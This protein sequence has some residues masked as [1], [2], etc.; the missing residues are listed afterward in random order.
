MT[1]RPV[2]IVTVTFEGLFFVRL[3]V[4]KIR[5]FTGDRPYE[6]IAVDRGSR[7][8]TRAWLKAQPDVR[9]LTAWQWRRNRHD[10]GRAAERG[11]RAAVHDVIVLVDSDAHPVA[12]D[13]LALTADRLS[14]STRLAG[15]RTDVRHAGNAHGWYV[16]PHF[17]VF[18][19]SDLDGLVVLRKVRGHDT[20]T[21]EEATIRML[22]AGYGVLG[23]PMAPWARFSRPC[24][25]ETRVP[26]VAAGVFH[27]WY[28]TR[29]LQHSDSVARGTEQRITRE[30]YLEPLQAALRDAY[31][32]AY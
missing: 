28:V 3:L 27:A 24:N 29:L 20:D 11:V 25:D 16:H 30:S 1:P 13:W 32:L 10:H 9:L 2:S 31:H 14:P 22:D 6:I 4:E 21:G 18:W 23:Y 15:A 19:K 12:P 7:D 5:E 26:T 8:G 17:M